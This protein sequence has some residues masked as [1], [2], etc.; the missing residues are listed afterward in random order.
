MTLRSVLVTT[1]LLALGCGSG[2]PEPPPIQTGPA[3]DA[4]K[5]PPGGPKLGAPLPADVGAVDLQSANAYGHSFQ[6]TDRELFGHTMGVR[7][8]VQ[9]DVVRHLSYKVVMPENVD[10]E[11]CEHI[12]EEL[13][14]LYGEPRAAGIPL[15]LPYDIWEGEIYAVTWRR[16]PRLEKGGLVCEVTWGPPPEDEADATP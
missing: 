13:T 16:R 5:G 14:A 9:D 15:I 3:V 2:E 8:D 7:A 11:R 1:A 6:L 10:I 4:A 12:R